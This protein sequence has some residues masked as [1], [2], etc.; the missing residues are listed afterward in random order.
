MM[1]A[2]TNQPDQP[3]GPT[4]RTAVDADLARAVARTARMRNGFYAV[5]LLVALG[6]QVTGATESLSMTVPV[7][8]LAVGALELGGM[9]VLAN[10]DVR[11]RLGERA[12]VSRLLSVGIAAGATGFNWL[13]HADHLRGGFFGGMSALGY[14]VWLMSTENARRDRLRATGDLPPT[15]PVYGWWRW[16]RHPVRTALARS[17]ALSRALD[18]YGSWDAALDVERAERATRAERRRRAVV[19]RLLRRKIRKGKDRLAANIATAVYDL[20]QISGRLTD[21]AD[22]TRLADLLAVDIHP[23]RVVGDHPGTEHLNRP[24]IAAPT[25]PARRATTTTQPRGN[26]NPQPTT[27]AVG[28]PPLR[29][30]GEPAAV[31]NARHLRTL[32]PTGLPETERAIRSA[33]GWSKVRVEPAVAAYLVGAD[34]VTN[35]EATG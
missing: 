14:L 12:I 29:L 23:D 1:A 16:T 31:V 8:L 17:L 15:A 5:V 33:T 9:V 35:Q 26:R 25:Q 19:G 18:L 22:Y 27:D 10:A 13:S 21:R 32:Y 6:G 4:N 28:R 2:M 34:L 11:R 7:A 20:D 3:T 30:V 24:A